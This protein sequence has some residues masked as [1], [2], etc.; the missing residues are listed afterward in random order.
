MVSRKRIF[1]CLLLILSVFLLVSAEKDTSGFKLK[2]YI[3]VDYKYHSFTIFPEIYFGSSSNGR[4]QNVSYYSLGP[5]TVIDIIGPDTIITIV[6]PY[7]PPPEFFESEGFSLR[8]SINIR[9]GHT[10]HYYTKKLDFQSSNYVSLTY[11]S[12]SFP[13]YGETFSK[14]DNDFRYTADV[15]HRISY[16]ISSANSAYRYLTDKFFVGL[17][18]NPGISHTP[19][20]FNLYERRSINKNVSN[21]DSSTYYYSENQGRNNNFNFLLDFNIQSGWGRLNDV[22]FAVVALNMLDR[23]NSITKNKKS[24]DIQSFAGFIEKLKRE[25]K[26]DFRYATI[27]DIEKIYH[28]LK[29]EGVIDYDSLSPRITMELVDQWEYADNQ[30]R[31]AG[32]RFALYPD[33]RIDLSRTSGEG[34]DV[35][36]NKIVPF[37]DDY[38]KEDLLDFST[39]N[40]GYESTYS[41]EVTSLFYSLI[42]AF[43]YKLP[44]NRFFQ[45]NFYSSGKIG[46]NSYFYKYKSQYKSSPTRGGYSYTYP[47]GIV[48]ITGFYGFYPNTRT[49]ISASASVDYLRNWDYI[50][51]KDEDGIELG[52]PEKDYRNLRLS[53]SSHLDYY[54]SP[55]FDF[56]ITAGISYS[57]LYTQTAFNSDTYYSVNSLSSDGLNFY[58]RGGI[59]YDIF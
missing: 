22:T 50:I 51:Y 55:R 59:N 27:D 38:S 43:S 2:D 35:S 19:Y 4:E 16:S 20:D 34:V 39:D 12:S 29:K 25:R 42:S 47:T 23:V 33:F 46:F 56:Y 21:I 17:H 3:P 10:F 14:S 53:L 45:W 49:T 41:S 7:V 28:Y 36:G 48:N 24:T 31:G 52:Y 40:Y 13:F 58:L 44:I 8:N 9:P 11:N 6:Y 26:Y 57:D 5:D 30:P 54:I 32:I 37:K 1:T 15:D 18:L